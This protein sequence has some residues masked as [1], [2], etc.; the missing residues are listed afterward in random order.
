M[1]IFI[2]VGKTY[3]DWFHSIDYSRIEKSTLYMTNEVT[4]KV[5]KHKTEQDLF[6]LILINISY[7][8]SL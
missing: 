3:T 4:N 8:F 1:I 5:L 2:I 6:I 7:L